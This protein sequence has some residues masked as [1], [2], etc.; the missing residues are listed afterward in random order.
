MVLANDLYVFPVSFIYVY[1]VKRAESHLE[2]RKIIIPQHSPG[3][4]QQ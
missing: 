3:L 4:Y 2:F 1:Y